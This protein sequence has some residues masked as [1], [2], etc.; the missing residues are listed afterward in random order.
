MY[1]EKQD[2]LWCVRFRYIPPYMMMAPMPSIEQIGI[3]GESAE[4]VW[5]KF[6]SEFPQ[7]QQD[8]VRKEE[9]YKIEEID[10]SP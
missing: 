1:N 3:R 2:M 7:E 4:D 5:K 6:L 10:E 8:W 9:I